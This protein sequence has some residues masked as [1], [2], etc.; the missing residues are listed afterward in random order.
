[1]ARSAGYRPADVRDRV[2]QIAEAFVAK[3]VATT[4]S[5]AALPGVTRGYVEEAAGL[6]EENALR[7]AGRLQTRRSPD[8]KRSNQSP[9]A[10]APG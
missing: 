9:R 2:L 10:G 8:T 6:I 5:V 1:M 7:I 3:R 4:E